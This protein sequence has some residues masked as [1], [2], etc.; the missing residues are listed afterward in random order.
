MAESDNNFYKVCAK[1]YMQPAFLIC[2]AVLAI[3]GGGMSMAIRHFGVY[4]EKEP[5]PL[6]KSLDLLDAG[7]LGPYKVVSKDQIT[8][9]DIL[10]S[11]GTED[12]IQWVLEDTEAPPQS[13]VRH[14][15][16]LITYYDLPDRV[17]HVPEECYTGSG[18]QRVTSEG[19]SFEIA[20]PGRAWVR[21][22]PIRY[23]VFSST[24]KSLWQS[25]VRFP[26]LYLFS[27]NGEYANSREDARLA[28]NK[29]IF[30]K[31]SYFSK[32]EW[33]FYNPGAGKTY[34]VKDEA[35]TAS[36]KLLK[37]ILPVLER[38]HWPQWQD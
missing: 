5:M 17:P 15:L 26:V 2:A 8:N 20:S 10:K 4:L 3:A 24:G 32:V 27:V 37:V 19:L 16:L 31:Y 14:C 22:I 6:K 30:G 25:E 12:Y 28:L 7:G 34:P 18:H 1:H 13:S 11:L 33:K 35:V 9:K 29:N 38:R 21:E 36:K 23:L